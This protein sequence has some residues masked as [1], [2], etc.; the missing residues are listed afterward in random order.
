MKMIIGA[1]IAPTQSNQRFFSEG[2]ID[3]IVSEELLRLLSSYDLRVFNLECP[4]TDS[5]KPIG[6]CGPNIKAPSS[7]ARGLKQLGANLLTL[8]NN[9]IMD[10]GSEGL[11][12]TARALD[13]EG[14]AH[15]GAGSG[16]LEAARPYVF[17]KDGVS[18]GFYACAEHEFSIADESHPGANPFEC[19]GSFEAVAALKADCDFAIVLY[20]GGKEQYRYPSPELRKVLRKFTECGAD[21]VIAQ[22]THCV[23]CMESHAGGVIVYGQGNFLFDAGD[24]EFWRTSLLLGVDISK[25]KLTVEYIPIEK[26][27]NGAGLSSDKGIMEG[28]EKRSEEILEDG[29]VEAMFGEFA[30]GFL[31]SF[32][33]EHR[34]FKRLALRIARWFLRHLMG[35]RLRLLLLNYVECESLREVLIRGLRE[36]LNPERQ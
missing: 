19:I 10:F 4:L 11:K 2:K 28:F 1:D 18:V 29:F 27:G 25:G 7:S 22:H 15:F 20:H 31:D 17:E 32:I 6:K 9:H 12:D 16:K 30:K 14:I 23:G 35:R 5:E 36:S 13:E 33:M 8:A 21:L 24:N 26:N 3:K 34:G